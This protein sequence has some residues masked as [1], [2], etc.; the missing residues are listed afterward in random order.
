MSYVTGR[1]LWRRPRPTASA[2]VP[3]YPGSA[4]TNCMCATALAIAQGRIGGF[5]GML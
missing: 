3:L 4:F 2:A 5:R 1:A